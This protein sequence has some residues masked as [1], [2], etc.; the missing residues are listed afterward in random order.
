MSKKNGYYIS[1]GAGDNQIPLIQAAK[2]RDLLVIG[3]DQNINA[4]GMSLCDLKI[5]ESILNY[6]KNTL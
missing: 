1:L 4:S 2:A 3:V 6:R 5:E